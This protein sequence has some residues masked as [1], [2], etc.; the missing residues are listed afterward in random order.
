VLIN[1]GFP[2]DKREKSLEEA[3]KHEGVYNSAVVGSNDEGAPL[4][5]GIESPTAIDGF[6][7]VKFGYGSRSMVYRAVSP[8]KL[9]G[10]RLSPKASQ[11]SEAGLRGG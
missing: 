6:T 10:G 11:A 3:A 2:K 5:S 8:V 4:P 9:E 7:H 1:C